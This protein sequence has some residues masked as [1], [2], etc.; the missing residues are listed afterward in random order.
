MSKPIDKKLY[1]KVKS[2]TRKNFKSY[3]SIYA[4]SWLV[5]EY[6]KRGG[7]YSGS[8]KN[9]GLDR[10]FKENWID[11]CKLPKLVKCGR[12]TANTKDW[13]SK[14]PYC[15]PYKRISK[16]TP[17]TVKEISKTE[18]KRRCSQKRK[19]PLTKIRSKR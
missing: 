4:N 11:V 1:E 2:I 6:K 9:R 7:R 13:K 12:S 3:P 5:K 16:E 17:K 10:W 19:N 14:Y 15:R 8:S 18:L